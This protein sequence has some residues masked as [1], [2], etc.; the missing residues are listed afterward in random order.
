MAGNHE[1][2]GGSKFDGSSL[3]RSVIARPL[4]DEMTKPVTRSAQAMDLIVDLNLRHRAGLSVAREL[5]YIEIVGYEKWLELGR[6]QDT[7]DYLEHL[8]GTE[9]SGADLR[10]WGG[11]TDKPL[12]KVVDLDKARYTPQY[13]YPKLTTKQIEKLI[14]VDGK[15][16]TRTLYKIWPD[17]DVEMML[18]KSVAT[19]KANAA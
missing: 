17:F 11:I 13:V 10:E 5:I 15:C 18:T 9:G 12:D 1:R 14:V 8:A 7:V 4:I 6:S 2:D 16:A 19:V 3:D